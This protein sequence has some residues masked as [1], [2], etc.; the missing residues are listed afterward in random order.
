MYDVSLMT[1]L[2]SWHNLYTST[3]REVNSK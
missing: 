3:H 2:N 1:I